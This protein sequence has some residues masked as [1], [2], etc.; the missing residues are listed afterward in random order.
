MA[1]RRR[2]SRSSQ[3]QSPSLSPKQRRGDDIEAQ[4]SAVNLPDTESKQKVSSIVS[5]RSSVQ[6]IPDDVPPNASC[7]GSPSL[8]NQLADDSTPQTKARRIH[9]ASGEDFPQA[10]DPRPV[11]SLS[12]RSIQDGESAI[13][14]NVPHTAV[15]DKGEVPLTRHASNKSP[16]M[17]ENRDA[18]RSE[19]TV[20]PARLRSPRALNI[21]EKKDERSELTGDASDTWSKC[22]EAVWKRE[23]TRLEILKESINY[24]LLFVSLLRIRF[25]IIVLT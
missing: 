1:R 9:V 10:A 4:I 14:N 22:A 5:T 12:K 16:P 7:N 23:K 25:L 24:L 17:N 3:S 20:L 2:R 15:G 19:D 11:E 21:G 18:T 8:D 6:R 13:R